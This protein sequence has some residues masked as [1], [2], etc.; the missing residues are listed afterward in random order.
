MN[1]VTFDAPNSPHEK[2]T[3][4]AH[5][6][7]KQVAARLP[8]A[9]M[10]LEDAD[11]VNPYFKQFHELGADRTEKIVRRAVTADHSGHDGAMG[12]VVINKDYHQF[13]YANLD[14]DKGKRLQDY[15]TMA[16]FSEVA[17]AL[18]NICDECIVPDDDG[19][20]IKLQ[21]RGEDLHSEVREELTKEFRRFISNFKLE[22]RGWEYFRNILVD[23]ELFF[24]NVISKNEPDLGIIGVLNVPAEYMEPVYDNVQ[25]MIIRGFLSKKMTRRDPRDKNVSAV[26]DAIQITPMAKQQICYIHS[27]IWNEDRSIRLPFIESARRAYK[28]LSLIE[29][30][31]VIY[32]LVRAPERLVFNVEVGNM[33]TPKAEAYIKSLMQKYWTKKSFDAS[34]NNPGGKVNVYDPQSMLDGYW[35]TK[36]NGQPGTTVDVLQ[37]GANLGQ[38]DDLIYFLKKLYKSLK[39]PTGRLDPTAVASDGADITREEL[40]FAKFII[41]LQQQFAS[42]LRESFIAHLKLRKLWEDYRLNEYTFTLIFNPPTSYHALRQQQLFELRANNFNTMISSDLISSGFAQKKWL[43]LSDEEIAANREFLRKDR[44]LLWELDSIQANGPDFREKMAADAKS[45]GGGGG[46]GGPPEFGPGPSTGPS[47]GP[48]APSGS[49]LPD[50]GNAGSEEGEG[51][52][53]E[54]PDASQATPEA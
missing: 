37:G 45:L 20:V 22:E 41:R 1:S 27:G 38:L 14:A 39:I 6:I 29:D 3:G 54:A 25:N 5:S 10:R 50:A 11:D 52:D 21:F 53:M 18:D 49:A 23:G 47:K 2:S 8:Q 44:A 4:F 33:P 17:E 16:V 24:E 34:G 36:R 19:E 12:N 26:P 48:A 28:Q 46:S 32:R 35:F 31:I 30:S 7:A 15:R 9:D 40:K 51:T 43:G 13:V 42:G